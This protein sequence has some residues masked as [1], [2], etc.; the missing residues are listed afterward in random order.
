MS[1]CVYSQIHYENLGALLDLLFQSRWLR[2]LP[3]LTKS[4]TPQIFCYWR[5]CIISSPALNY[6]RF[7]YCRGS[8]WDCILGGIF[9]NTE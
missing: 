6:R 4:R 3:L 5:L 1:S 7:A 9:I 8:L 2:I